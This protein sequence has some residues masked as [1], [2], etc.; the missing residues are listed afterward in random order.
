MSDEEF[1]RVALE[2]AKKGDFPFGAVIVKNNKVISK[3][4]NTM[5][6]D[7]DSTAHAEI[8][9]IRKACKKL[10]SVKIP[11]CTLYVTANPCLM[12]FSAVWRAGIKRIVYGIEMPDKMGVDIQTLNQIS[13]N[14]IKIKAGVLKKEI[15]ELFKDSK[16]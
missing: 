1:M 7:V 16:D 14:K 8:N 4:Y 5:I 11:D 9:A 15:L 2:E 12:C 13:G 6:S 10:N 3:S